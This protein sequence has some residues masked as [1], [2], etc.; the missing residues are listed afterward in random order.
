M[1]HKQTSPDVVIIGGGLAGLTAA[2]FLAR[3]GQSVR[4]YEKS[5]QLG[6]RGGTQLKNGFFFNLGPHAL[7]KAGAGVKVL[8]DLGITFTGGTPTVGGYVVNAGRKDTL[9]GNPLTLLTTK[10]L[11]FRSKLE[12]GRLLATIGKLDPEPFNAMTVS[13]W[14]AQKIKEPATRALLKALFRLST[15]TNDP[16]H[17][18]AGA[19]LAQLKISIS[20]NVYYLDEGWQTLVDGLRQ[21]AQVS[22]AT[23][24]TS[25]RVTK[26]TEDD[27]SEGKCVHLSDGTVIPARAVVIAASPQVSYELFEHSDQTSLKQWADTA[28]PILASCLDVGLKSLP[29]PQAKF[30][31]GI[32]QPLYLS[33]HSAVARLMPEGGALIHTAKYL[34]PNGASDPKMDE[35]ELEHLLDLVQPGWREVIIEKRFLPK[36]TVAHGV[37][38]A[39]A[40]GFVNRPGPTVPETPNLYVVGD[41]VGPEGMLSDASFASA[42]LAAQLI[43]RK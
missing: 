38:T 5:H 27:N 22:G 41:W 19:A 42:K 28:R 6:G 29:Q 8:S 40:S 36:M 34:H 3:A 23:L 16:D 7:Y 43:L 26:V 17:Q 1:T 20:D 21:A 30:A 25:C 11:G 18:S 32:D 37:V 39:A 33:V 10:A 9:P 24:I 15:Y 31:L 2:T 35:Q 13:D 12:V 4:L 14:V